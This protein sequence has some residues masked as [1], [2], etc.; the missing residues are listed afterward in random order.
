MWPAV[1]NRILVCL[2]TAQVILGTLLSIKLSPIASG[3]VIP[4]P[5]LT[6]LFWIYSATLLRRP[7]SSLSTR[8]MISVDRHRSQSTTFPSALGDKARR[9]YAQPALS[10][11]A[12]QP[13][14]AALP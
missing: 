8:E 10:Y 1:A 7:A 12:L 11:A 6:A 2:F 5:F 14:D 13:T 9:H 3:I 4:L